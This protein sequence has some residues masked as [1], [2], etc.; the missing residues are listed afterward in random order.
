MSDKICSACLAPEGEWLGSAKARCGHSMCLPCCL[1]WSKTN[2]SCPECRAEF[3]PQAQTSAAPADEADW[4]EDLSGLVMET[5]EEVWARRNAERRQRRQAH[6]AQ[7]D[8][9]NERRNVFL[10]QARLDWTAHCA[11]CTDPACLANHVRRTNWL[12][13]GKLVAQ[14]A[15]LSTLTKPLLGLLLSHRNISRTK[16]EA[17]EASCQLHS[18]EFFYLQKRRHGLLRAIETQQTAAQWRKSAYSATSGSIVE[19]LGTTLLCARAELVQDADAFVLKHTTARKVTVF[20]GFTPPKRGARTGDLYVR[21]DKKAICVGF[22]LWYFS[23]GSRTNLQG[24]TWVVTP[25]ID[26]EAVD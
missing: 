22:H 19:R 21:D 17:L 9:S 6:E 4:G 18:T 8:A 26:F 3:V 15:R 1:T 14:P 11:T 10:Q 5:Y 2:A 23:D 7:V 13:R 16:I 12:E 20:K 24:N 25:P